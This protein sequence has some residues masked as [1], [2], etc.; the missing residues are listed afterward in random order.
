MAAEDRARWDARHY[1]RAL[2]PYP[3][4]DALLVAYAPPANLF[5]PPQALDLA[6]GQCQNAIWLA[7]QGYQVDAVDISR[8]ALERGRAEMAI[9]NLRS[10]NFI[11]MD[12]D[13]PTLAEDHYDLVCI[14][15]FLNRSLFPLLRSS[16]KPGG[17]IIYQTF[18][19]RLRLTG[20]EFRSDYLLVPGEL[21]TLFPGWTLLHDED[22][23]DTSRLV[24]RKPESD[25]G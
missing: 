6:A 21:P 17:L 10:V 4:P 15:R 12:L 20:R 5:S 11:P 8:V 16:I 3:P 1:A 22:R 13:R 19:T 9:R 18:N 7:D 23:G 25:S 14:F 2:A 24:A